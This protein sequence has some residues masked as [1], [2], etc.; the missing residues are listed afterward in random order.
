MTHH[1]YKELCLNSEVRGAR[2]SRS[3]ASI[4]I[5]GWNGDKLT[6]EDKFVVPVDESM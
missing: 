5:A 1:S 6:E 2:A 3:V 4:R